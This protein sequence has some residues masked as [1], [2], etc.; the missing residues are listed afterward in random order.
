MM[1]MVLMACVCGCGDTEDGID[2]FVLH[3]SPVDTNFYAGDTAH[4]SDSLSFFK[5]TANSPA[6]IADTMFK[7]I[8]QGTGAFS[9]S[10]LSLSSGSLVRMRTTL[11]DRRN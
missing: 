10:S 1:A 9:L 2:V 7:S 8:G 4:K 5:K 11:S 6:S 3:P